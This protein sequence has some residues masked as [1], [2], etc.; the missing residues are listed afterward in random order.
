MLQRLA[1]DAPLYTPHVATS[2]IILGIDSE[3]AIWREVGDEVVILDVSSATYFS[4]NG[5]GKLLWHQLDEGSTLQGLVRVLEEA[6]SISTEQAQKDTEAFVS[7]LL[8]ASLVKHLGGA[9]VDAG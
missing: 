3:R 2:D 5:S 9:V 6:Y 1:P 7:A 8:D 4:L